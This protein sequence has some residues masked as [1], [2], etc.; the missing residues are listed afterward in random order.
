MDGGFELRNRWHRSSQMKWFGED[1]GAR[2]CATLKHH[3]TPVG[4]LCG[5]CTESIEEGQCGYMVPH[6]ERR[7]LDYKPWH[8]ECFM[9]SAFGSIAHQAKLC[10]CYKNPPD[11][12]GEREEGMTPRQAALLTYK[13]MM[14]RI[15]ETN[16]GR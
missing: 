11:D 6:L 14:E 13:W 2:A 9:R 10:G 7:A 4:E 16:E 8:I 15:N 12:E 5:W 3:P 1:F